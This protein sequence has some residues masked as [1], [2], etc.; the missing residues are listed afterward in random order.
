MP[1]KVVE[2]KVAVGTKVARG[3]S[4]AVLSA[5]K[6]ETVVS[7]T[8]AGTVTKVYAHTHTHT[9]TNTDTHALALSTHSLACRSTRPRTT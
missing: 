8:V 6:M 9:T 3:Q 2:I 1:G 4:I 7:A 5:M